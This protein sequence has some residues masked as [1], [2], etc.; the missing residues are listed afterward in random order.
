LNT[1][2]QEKNQ[3]IPNKPKAYLNWILLDE[4][5]KY[6][7]TWPQSGA[8]PVE[9]ADQV[10]ALTSGDIDITK[11]GY[12]YIYVSN[13]TE[14]WNVFF[15]D[16]T[17]THKTGPLLE[18]THYYPFGLT[19]AG[20]SSKALNPN[21]AENK[22]KFN[23]G[24][25]LN[26]SFD[27]NLYE[28]NFRS[29]D[30]QIG[31]F[32]Q[33][34]PYSDILHELSPYN[35]ASNNPISR[36]DPLGLNDTVVNGQQVQRDKDLEPVTVTGKSMKIPTDFLPYIRFRNG[37][38]YSVASLN[39]WPA[40]W[41]RTDR[42]NDLVDSWVDGI[43]AENRVYLPHHPMTRR[44]TNARAVSRARAY[45]YKKYV[46]NFK[47]GQSLKGA[48]VTNYGGSFGLAGLFMAGP[49]IVEQF[50]GTMDIEIQVDEKGENLLFMVSNTTS[51][52]SAFYRLG[53][54]F[55][56]DPN[57]ITP[58][59]NFNQLYIWKE[60]VSKALAEEAMGVDY[61]NPLTDSHIFNW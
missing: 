16:L 5:F 14:N 7:G 4:Q 3:D 37:R 56:R 31:R 61:Y 35:Y 12:L 50:V 23:G 39:D 36:N 41:D 29:L 28:T 55:D 8:K 46:T 58:M 13:E 15:D 22:R 32:W 19:M 30:P 1:F 45:F 21:Y 17:I 48:S 18:E 52:T 27:I 33:I 43:G 6:V 9:G 25:E 57:Q 10:K 54:S 24:T 26:T 2:R 11:N 38:P 34:D 42:M 49:D 44:L 20:I 51:V 47:N 53:T 40:K 59:G 60:P